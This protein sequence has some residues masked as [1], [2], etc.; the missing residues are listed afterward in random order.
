MICGGHIIVRCV[1]LIWYIKKN[2]NM[3]VNI[4]MRHFGFLFLFL[5]CSPFSP[6]YSSAFSSSSKMYIATYPC[7]YYRESLSIAPYIYKMRP[8]VSQLT[9]IEIRNMRLVNVM[10]TSRPAFC[11]PVFQDASHPFERWLSFILYNTQKKGKKGRLLYMYLP[12]CVSFRL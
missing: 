7:V 5:F 3:N 11:P 2:I 1:H 4:Y 8:A 10:W 12:C 6:V 9:Q